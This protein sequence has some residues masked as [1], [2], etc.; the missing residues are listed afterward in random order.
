LPLKFRQSR[1]IEKWFGNVFAG[2]N[3]IPSPVAVCALGIPTILDRLI[4]QALHQ[5]LMRRT[6]THKKNPFSKPKTGVNI[7]CEDNQ[8]SLRR[9]GHPLGDP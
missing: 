1:K 3:E 7:S 9:L 6:L 8:P 5:E 2:W 4:Q